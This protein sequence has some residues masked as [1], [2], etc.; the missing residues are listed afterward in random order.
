MQKLTINKLRLWARL[1]C[2][3]EERA[4]VQPIDIDVVIEFATLPKGCK[5]DD[6]SDVYCYKTIIEQMQAFLEKNTFNLIEC[7]TVSLYDFI[8]A[9][10]KMKDVKMT[11]RVTKIHPPIPFVHQGVAFEYS[12]SEKCR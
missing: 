12:S 9:Q 8:Y 10:L 4:N 5:T 3:E 1:G 7:L 2:G 6:L 11:L